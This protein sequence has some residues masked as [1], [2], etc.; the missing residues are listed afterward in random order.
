V[1]AGV[2]LLE[3]RNKNGTDEAVL[4]DAEILR[5]A[6]PVGKTRLVLD[7][8]IDLVDRTG[9]DG[10]HVDAG[11]E[12][13]DFARRIL[14]PER[15]VGT[16]GGSEALIQ[17]V[18]LSPA[19]YFS[20]GPV[21]PTQTKQTT[22]KPIGMEGV[23]KLRAQAGA[24]PVLVAVGGLRLDVFVDVLA[25]GASTVA[26]SAALFRQADPAAEFVRWSKEI[27]G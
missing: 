2:T 21:Y 16:F 13:P 8:R 14:G 19:D 18:L 15:I 24:A 6:M 22:K 27:G 1:D 11:D 20:I 10:V 26:V 25:A 5:D 7:D 3:Y 12:S 17:N 9:F 4:A 23:R